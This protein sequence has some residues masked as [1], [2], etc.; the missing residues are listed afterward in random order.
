MLDISISIFAFNYLLDL[1]YYSYYTK[2]QGLFHQLMSGR[3][4]MIFCFYTAI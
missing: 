2:L 3:Y 4:Y 1:R